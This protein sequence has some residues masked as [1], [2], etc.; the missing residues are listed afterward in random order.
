MT[1]KVF[2]LIIMFFFLIP[3]NVFPLQ[4]KAHSVKQEYEKQDELKRAALRAVVAIKTIPE[5]C[6]NLQLC[7]FISHIRSTPEL[8]FLLESVQKD[9]SSNSNEMDTS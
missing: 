3:W 2:F 8:D 1:S 5:S 7:D 9:S 4:V 6:K